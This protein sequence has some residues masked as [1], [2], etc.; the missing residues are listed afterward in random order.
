MDAFEKF[1]GGRGKMMG[2][3]TPLSMQFLFQE[4]LSDLQFASVGATSRSH[5]LR[6]VLKYI[7]NMLAERS[8]SVSAA[9]PLRPLANGSPNHSQEIVHIHSSGSARAVV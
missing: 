3:T 6:K 4:L 9:I 1:V 7:I 8:H 5:V 2:N